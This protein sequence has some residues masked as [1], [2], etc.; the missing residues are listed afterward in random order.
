MNN[1]LVRLSAV[2]I[3]GTSWVVAWEEVLF[4][5][6]WPGDSI[7]AAMVLLVPLM[8]QFVVLGREHGQLYLPVKV[9][10]LCFVSGLVLFIVLMSAPLLSGDPMLTS[11][12]G[13]F[14]NYHLSSTLLFEIAIFLIMTG[15]VVNVL[16]GYREPH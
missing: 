6:T 10:G 9:F 11:F 1:V 15:V 8:L 2:M 16:A 7:T 4:S 12:R 5:E 3:F 13:R 14:G